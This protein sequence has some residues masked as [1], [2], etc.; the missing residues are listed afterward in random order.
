MKEESAINVVIERPGFEESLFDESHAPERFDS[1]L[2]SLRTPGN[3]QRVLTQT[4]ILALDMLATNTYV[5]ED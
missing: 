1:L 3:H 2:S 4:E 5:E